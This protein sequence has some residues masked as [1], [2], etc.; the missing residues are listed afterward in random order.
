M[1]HDPPY[2]PD[3]VDTLLL[4]LD[5]TLLDLAFD[6]RFWGVVVPEAYG[7]LH[8][9]SVQQ[10]LGE[11]MPRL[12]AVE[13]TLPWY[14]LDHW[15][16]ALGMDLSRL[17]TENAGHVAWLPGAR[18]FLLRQ[19]AK[20]RRLVLATN[21]HPE[22][23]RIKMT[24]VPV[25]DYLDAAYSSHPFGAPKE[26]PRFW[27]GFRQIEHFD[28]QRTA[29]I[30]DNLNVLRAARAAGI[31]HPIAVTRPD[32]SQP[33]KSRPTEFPWVFAVADLA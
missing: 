10:A 19:K 15:S 6:N 29:F 7:E 11:I 14:C 4:D 22:T 33:E 8:G 28:P 2:I 26:D 20:G 25:T 18:E 24:Q 1:T 16:E 13:G 21:S 27:V 30:D 9:L 5:G 31:A 12:R 3:H 32:T 23:L 17:K